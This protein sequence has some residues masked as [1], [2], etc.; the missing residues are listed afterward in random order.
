MK[1]LHWIIAAGAALI[2]FAGGFA[3]GWVASRWSLAADMADAAEEIEADLDG[4][5]QAAPEEEPDAGT[6]AAPAGPP[7]P[8]DE[9]TDGLFT[10]AV[11]VE[12]RDNYNDDACGERYQPG[13]GAHYLVVQVEATNVGD[14]TSYPAVDP[15]EVVGYAE[16]GRAFESDWDICSFADETNPGTSTTYEVVFETP[17]DVTFAVVELAAFEAPDVAVVAAG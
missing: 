10:Y 2:V 16:D 17:A 5:G 8:T 1:P 7:E 11:T 9:P 12:A 15:G 14:A 6:E 3:G 4:S 13:E